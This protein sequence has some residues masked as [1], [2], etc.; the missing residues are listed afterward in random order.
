MRENVSISDIAS[1]SND[2][3]RLQINEQ[4]TI[5]SDEEEAVDDEFEL[6]QCISMSPRTIYFTPKA[7]NFQPIREQASEIIKLF[8]DMANNMDR[9]LGKIEITACEG[10]K[11]YLQD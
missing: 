6:N 1:T 9:N 4:R 10:H 7:R 2:G 3:H 11:I 8:V 5:E